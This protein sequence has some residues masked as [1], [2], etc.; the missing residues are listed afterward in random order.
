M[1]AFVAARAGDSVA[2][3]GADQIV[4]D[5][6][7]GRAA[8]R[9][10]V[11]LLTDLD[12]EMLNTE[13]PFPCVWIASWR[14]TDGIGPLRDSLVVSVIT[15]DDN[16]VDDLLDEPTIANVYRGPVPTYYTATG[17]PHDGFLADFLMRT[18]GFVNG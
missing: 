7:D 9:P 2:F 11:H 13:L 18:K 1:A 17:L 16:L 15:E 8:L 12:T 5:L 4:A 10:A 3:L 6:G 14:R